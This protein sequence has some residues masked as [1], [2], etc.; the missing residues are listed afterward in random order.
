VVKKAGDDFWDG[1]FSEARTRFILFPIP[2]T[3]VPILRTF[4]GA[5]LCFEFSGSAVVLV[6]KYTVRGIPEMKSIGMDTIR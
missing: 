4:R 6:L 1:C 2:P 3:I 5:L